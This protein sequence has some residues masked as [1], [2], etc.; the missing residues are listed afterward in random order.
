MGYDPLNEI[1][2]EVSLFCQ[3]A[4]PSPRGRVRS[5]VTIRDGVPKVTIKDR[6]PKVTI[7][8]RVPKVTGSRAALPA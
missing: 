6:V 1:A 5:W 8:G 2:A 4:R 3:M 7:R